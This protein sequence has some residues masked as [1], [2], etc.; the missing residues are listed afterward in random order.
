MMSKLSVGPWALV[1]GGG[2]EVE[3]SEQKGAAPMHRPEERVG[4]R[5]QAARERGYFVPDPTVS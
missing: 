1:L 3:L 5:P 4:R 2:G